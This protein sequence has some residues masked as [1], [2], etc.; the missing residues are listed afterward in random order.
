MYYGWIIVIANFFIA[1]LV[2]GFIFYSF[3]GFFEAI[4]KDMGFTYT[5]VSLAGSLRGLEM[6][7]FAPLAGWLVDRFG[8]RRLASTGIVISG[9]GMLLLG[10]TRSL[11]SFY[12]AFLIIALG[13][14]LC[15][16][17]VLISSV[18][19]WFERNQGLAI[20]I[21]T[22]GFALSGIIL[23]LLVYLIDSL[24]WRETVLLA[25]LLILSCG[26]PLSLLLRES[27]L[28]CASSAHKASSR[29]LM[30]IV[31]ERNLFV[32]SLCEGL[33]FM[34]VST[35]VIHIMPYLTSIKVERVTASF[36]A[37][38]IPLLSIAGRFGFGF[39]SDIMDKRLTMALTYSFVVAGMWLLVQGMVL[40]FAFFFALGYGGGISVRGTLLSDY[41]ETGNYGKAL[42]VLMGFS[43]VGGVIGPSLA[44]AVFDSKGT[45]EP[46]WLLYMLAS[47]SSAV[48]VLFLDDRK[49]S[50]GVD[51]FQS[52]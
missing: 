3:T 40:P 52:L 2:G 15:S 41:L 13:A 9:S 43:S 30:S 46:V 11:L 35:V 26:I 33:R 18:V 20:G 42:G 47:I 17:V 36:I 14:G 16:T 51:H 5:Q 4:V 49:R 45:Y 37:S 21:V 8:A 10:L 34:V 12:G 32:L 44:G 39:L 24:G 27:P 29:S 1:F 50:K 31:K 19:S 25:G 7:L 22:S 38:S 23:P 48:L 6:G 28:Q